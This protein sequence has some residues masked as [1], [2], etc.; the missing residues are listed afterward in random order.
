MSPCHLKSQKSLCVTSFWFL[1]IFSK[2]ST[3]SCKISS[4]VWLWTNKA[5]KS[6]KYLFVFDWLYLYIGQVIS[7]SH[8]S[9]W[10]TRSLFHGVLQMS[11]S[12]TL[13][14]TLVLSLPFCFNCLFCTM[15]NLKIVQTVQV[16]GA[17]R[18]YIIFLNR[19]ISHLTH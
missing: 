11:L 12:L 8:W 5:F 14:F 6:L 16:T 15:G 4:Y 7:S 9:N 10:V 13:S 17:K 1:D 2:K 18:N 19:D 3:M